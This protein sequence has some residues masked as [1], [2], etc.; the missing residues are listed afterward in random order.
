MAK[1]FAGWLG[2]EVNSSIVNPR[3]KNQA[4]NNFQPLLDIPDNEDNV[5]EVRNNGM[6][7]IMW[8]R[9]KPFHQKFGYAILDNKIELYPYQLSKEL[10]WQLMWVN[11]FLDCCRKGLVQKEVLEGDFVYSKQGKVFTLIAV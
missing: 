10:D 9:N 4:A 1:P 2:F 8:R 6:T 11:D 3:P 5:I 7:S